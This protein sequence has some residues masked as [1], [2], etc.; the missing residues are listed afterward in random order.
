M[1]PAIAI[2]SCH[3]YSDRRQAQLDTWLQDIDCD[4]FFLIGNP[5]PGNGGPVI[6]DSLACDVSDAFTDIAPKILFA[7]MYALQENITNL[8]VVDDD[9]YLVPERLF[10]SGFEKFDYLGFVRSHQDVPYMQGSCYCLSERSMAR[11]I[12]PVEP[13]WMAPGVPDDFAVGRCLYGEVPYTHEHRFVVGD[14]YPGPDRWPSPKNDVI[15]CHKANPKVMRE[16]H[17]NRGLNTSPDKVRGK[18]CGQ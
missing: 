16:I 9:T 10:K 2:K 15:S 1:K 18:G 5:T 17:C 4:F 3:R 12:K 8:C 6:M 7:C 11:I 13:Y 14:P